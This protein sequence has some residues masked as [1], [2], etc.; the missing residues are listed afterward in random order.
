MEFKFKQTSHEIKAFDEKEGIVEAYANVYEFEDS[1]GDISEVG[2]FNK[3]IE[4][5]AKRI[6]VLKDHNKTISLG[7]PIKMDANDPTGLLTVS[8]FNLQK[9]VSR[10]MFSDIML[11][12][13]NGMNAELSIGYEVIQRDAKNKNRIKEYKLWEYSFLTSWGANQLSMVQDLKTIK[14]HYGVMELL[15]KMYNLPH[16]DAR[17]K[18]VEKILQSLTSNEPIDKSLI[19]E[20]A[21]INQLDNLKN[22]LKWN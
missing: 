2:S 8:K 9:E 11:M 16:S 19:N 22:H 7:V 12:K 15:T 6:R 18:A 13:D 10:D 5:N 20:E 1:D 4:Q 3:T 21:V 14:T 17:L